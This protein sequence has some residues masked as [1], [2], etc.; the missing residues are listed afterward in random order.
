MPEREPVLVDRRCAVQDRRVAEQLQ[1]ASTAQF[2]RSVDAE[3]VPEQIHQRG[4]RSCFFL[5]LNRP[6]S[7]T[8]SRRG[9]AAEAR[10]PV[11]GG[12]LLA[13]GPTVAA[14]LKAVYQYPGSRQC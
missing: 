3:G 12:T 7:G 13:T 10:A 9:H 14:A 2:T 8:I 6:K 4:P 5:V 1:C 11:R